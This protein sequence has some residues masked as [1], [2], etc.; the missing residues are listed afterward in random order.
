VDL[1]SSELKPIYSS[2]AR[3]YKDKGKGKGKGKGYRQ[4]QHR[5]ISLAMAGS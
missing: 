4:V 3:L 1:R 2:R 5:P